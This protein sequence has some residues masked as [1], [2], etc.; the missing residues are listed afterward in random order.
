MS[1]SGH[2]LLAGAGLTL[3]L[4]AVLTAVMGPFRSDLGAA[5]GGLVLVLPV[6][7]GT[8]AG[9]L[10]AGIFALVVDFVAYDVVFVPPYGSFPVGDW[11]AFVALA[12]Y[13][14]VVLALTRLVSQLASARA[15]ARRRDDHVRRLF[16]LS[17]LLVGELAE[18]D[19]L[20]RVVTA[21][22][23]A[24][25]MSS[26]V[27][28]LERR[29][30]LEPVAVAGAPWSASSLAALVPRAGV[31]VRVDIADGGVRSLVL[32]ATGAPVGLLGL[33]GPA[34]G[35]ED[36]ELLRALANHAAL[37]LERARLR[38]QAVRTEVLEET[39]RLQ[40][41]LMG[42][43]SHDLRTPLAT[44]KV[45]A[46]T[47][48][49]AEDVLEVAERKELLDTIDSEADRLERLVR[50]LLDMT[51]IQAGALRVMPEPLWI[52]DLVTDTLG[53]LDAVLAGHPLTVD[54]AGELPPVLADHLLVGQVLANLLENAARHSPPG[55]PL[56]ITA[57]QLDGEVVMAVT[58]RGPGL[59]ASREQMF[60]PFRGGGPGQGTGV[61]LSIAK[62]FVEAHGRRIWAEDV[63][64]G[65]TRFCFSLATAADLAQG[66]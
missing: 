35:E 34:L 66:R 9:G 47:L 49:Q 40:K 3:L 57:R 22:H 59:G 8:M 25:S 63:E 14:A 61:G 60:E 48:R 50:N 46:S 24:F 51:R 44:I 56:S 13:A 19:L 36:G 7:V 38:E 15:E 26:V 27:V 10:A 30:Q 31:P 42:A 33:D 18:S 6:V 65:G 58:D 54:V 28:L 41:A 11:R 12:V 62:A 4:T 1:L 20:E 17:D 16:E 23:D 53:P 29:E 5:S 52:D 37:S 43:V 55:T 64:G 39:E 32:A 45:S 2:R 21:V